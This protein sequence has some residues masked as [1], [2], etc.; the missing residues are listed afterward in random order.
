MGF[1]APKGP[2]PP[3]VV[4]RIRIQYAKRGRLRFSSH[5]DFQRALERALRR[6]GVPMAYSAGFHPHPKISFAGAAPTGTASEAEYVELALTDR[7]ELSCLHHEL[8]QSLPTGLDVV[9]VV[10]AGEQPLADQLEA[11]QWRIDVH[12]DDQD[13]LRAAVNAFW[14]AQC[15]EVQ[16]MGKTGVRRLDARSPVE[17]ICLHADNDEAF[18]DM[19]IR[20]VVP[21]VRPQEVL[22]ALGQVGSLS[23]VRILL[24]TRMSQGRFVGNQIIDPLGVEAD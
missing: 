9:R 22:S 8:D 11:S 16:R 3:P 6:S 5:R 2:P 15:I 1:R 24:M 20:H 7:I 12:T 17:R 21:A 18:L 4:Q 19:V 14:S 10:Q 23:S 13:S